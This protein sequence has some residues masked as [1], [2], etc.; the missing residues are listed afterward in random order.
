MRAAATHAVKVRV[1]PEVG[2]PTIAEGDE[3]AEPEWGVD[4]T[5]DPGLGRRPARWILVAVL[6]GMVLAVSLTVLAVMTARHP[7]TGATPG[8]QPNPASVADFPP[9]GPQS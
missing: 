4:L 6:A 3:F 2:T 7:G 9:A 1:L 8:G 5:S